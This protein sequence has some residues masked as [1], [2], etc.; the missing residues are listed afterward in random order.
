MFGGIS[1]GTV[2]ALKSEVVT[3]MLLNLPRSKHQW[4]VG[5]AYLSKAFA[6]ISL[7]ALNRGRPAKAVEKRASLL[8]NGR[9]LTVTRSRSAGPLVD[10]RLI[11]SSLLRSM[12]DNYSALK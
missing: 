1:D 5:N 4:L 12:F 2:I 3:L 8:L 11:S 10:L 9:R 7:C 6:H